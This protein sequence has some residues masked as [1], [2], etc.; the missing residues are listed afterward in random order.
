MPISSSDQRTPTEQSR[1]YK[2]LVEL[3]EQRITFNEFLGFK[4]DQLEKRPFRVRFDMRPELIGHYQYGRL[5]GGVISSVL[6]ATGGMAVM[7]A[8]TD[9]HKA[10]LLYTSP[11]P[12]D[13]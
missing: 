6:D 4:I 10:C 12:R 7:I 1:I 3:F 5:H 9:F 2:E 8:I 11:S 13:S